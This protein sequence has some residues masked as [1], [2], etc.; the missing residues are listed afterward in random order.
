MMHCL[1]SFDLSNIMPDFSIPG[2]ASK[3]KVLRECSG[4]RTSVFP[5]TQFNLAEN[6]FFYYRRYGK[7]NTVGF[8]LHL[9][10]LSSNLP[11]AFLM[12]GQLFPTHLSPTFVRNS[13]TATPSSPHTARSL[14]FLFLLDFFMA[15]PV[16]VTDTHVPSCREHTFIPYLT[17]HW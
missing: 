8:S 6:R 16:L 9:G 1:A 7:I 5:R 11:R 12:S 2:G 17:I 15:S 10:P 14:K 4:L 13:R 3:V